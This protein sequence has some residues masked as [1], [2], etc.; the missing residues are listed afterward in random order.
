MSLTCQ[1]CHKKF[2][3]KL[4]LQ[5]H[6]KYFHKDFDEFNENFCCIFCKKKF[7]THRNLLIHITIVHSN[8]HR[9]NYCGEKFSSDIFRKTH[10]TTCA[11]KLHKCCICQKIFKS[12]EILTEHEKEHFYKCDKCPQ[13][14]SSKINLE[15]HMKTYIHNQNCCFICSSLFNSFDKLME[16]INTHDSDKFELFNDICIYD[17]QL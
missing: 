9:C 12:A 8:P 5:L 3:N 17:E 11:L 13:I 15:N 16:H 4:H 14:F 7:T 6:N 10:Q 1:E 2:I